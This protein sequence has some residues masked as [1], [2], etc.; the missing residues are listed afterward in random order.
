MRSLTELE[1]QLV[2]QNEALTK[3]LALL[4]EQ[5]DFLTKKLFGRSSEKTS[6]LAGQ[7]D[8]FED[9]TFFNCAETTEEKNVV[10]E[11]Q[12]K[13][14][15]RIGY[16]T[17]LTKDLPIK[18]MHCELKG[19][20][21]TCDWCNSTFHPIGKTSVHEEVIFIPATMY[22]KVYYQHAYEYLTCK[23]DGTDAIKKRLFLSKLLPTVLLH[24]KIEMSLPFYRQE[25]EWQIMDWPFHVVP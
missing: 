17:E 11:I 10:E 5:V 18:E 24:Q 8:L 1:E 7:V 25:K 21:C 9:D 16:K 2:K 3:E 12:Y 22:K 13:Q 4:R 23:K 15:K 14:K 20:E 6:N 19:K